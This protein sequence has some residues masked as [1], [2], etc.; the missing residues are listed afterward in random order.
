MPGQSRRP[1][2]LTFDTFEGDFT[3]DGDRCTF[4]GLCLR[5]DLR[6][7]RLPTLAELVHDLDVKDGRYGRPEAP[8]LGALVEGLRLVHHDDRELLAHGIA[9]FEALS[10]GHV[11]LRTAPVAVTPAARRRTRAQARGT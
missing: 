2:T 1:R 3:H 8:L 9:L 6:D 11:V 7:P 5:F 10:Q 4:E